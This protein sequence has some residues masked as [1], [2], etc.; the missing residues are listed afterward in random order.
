[1][2]KISLAYRV[3]NEEELPRIKKVN[4]LYTTKSMKD[5]RIRHVL[6]SSFLLKHVI[7]KEKNLQ[8]WSEDKEEDVSS[9]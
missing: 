8:K 9:Y 2:Q 6:R 3:R 5:N 4:I 7:K 1:M